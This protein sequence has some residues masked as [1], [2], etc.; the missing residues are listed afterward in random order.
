MAVIADIVSEFSF[1]ASEYD[2]A[3]EDVTGLIKRN[4]KVKQF[5]QKSLTHASASFRHEISLLVEKSHTM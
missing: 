5:L 2:K 3:V 4:L 1:G